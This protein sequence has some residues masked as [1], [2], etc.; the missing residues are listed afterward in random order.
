MSGSR[1]RT[2]AS[3]LDPLSVR[4]H[5]RKDLFDAVKSGLVPQLLRTHVPD[6]IQKLNALQRSTPGG[7]WSTPESIADFALWCVNHENEPIHRRLSD[8]LAK[9]IP[10]DSI[11]LHLLQPAARYLG[12]QWLADQLSFVDVKIGLC[13]LH[14]LLREC[15]G[16]AFSFEN[17]TLDNG[18]NDH[19]YSIMLSNTPGDQ[20]SFGVAMVSDFFRR[21]GW[22]VVNSIGQSSDE[23]VAN[24]RDT[25][26]SVCGFSLHNDGHFPVLADLIAQVRRTASNQDMMVIVGGDYFLRNPS[27]VVQVGADLTA[28]DAHNTLLKTFLQLENATTEKIHA[29]A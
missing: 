9:Q 23:I 7:V 29:M 25:S 13:R 8:L 18:G 6:S 16:I 4:Q 14:G 26:F 3:R 11:Y 24:V 19:Q 28:A 17:V 5:D 27:H 2:V 10:L 1:G 12:D 15:E 21:Q 22:Q 20:H